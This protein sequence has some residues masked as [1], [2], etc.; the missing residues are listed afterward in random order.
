MLVGGNKNFHLNDKIKGSSL[1]FFWSNS[2][3]FKWFPGND[4]DPNKISNSIS[5]FA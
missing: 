1:M 3:E 2:L 4:L 5:N